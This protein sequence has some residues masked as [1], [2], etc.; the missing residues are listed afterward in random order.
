MKRL[1]ILNLRPFQQYCISLPHP[2]QSSQERNKPL[3]APV[4]RSHA[5]L[6][7]QQKIPLDINVDIRPA[8]PTLT[9]SNHGVF[10]PRSLYIVLT[11]IF[12]ATLEFSLSELSLIFFL[13]K[14]EHEHCFWYEWLSSGDISHRDAW[15]GWNSACGAQSPEN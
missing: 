4:M 11:F 10:S 15:K 3:H 8:S 2:D 14:E 9:S 5:V 1:C 13:I 12:I 6:T 7:V